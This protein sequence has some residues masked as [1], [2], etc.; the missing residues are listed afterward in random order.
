MK[1][2]KKLIS[3]VLICSW[4]LFLFAYYEFWMRILLKESSISQWTFTT[5][6]IAFVLIVFWILG[7]L[8]RIINFPIKKILKI[9]TIPVNAITLWLFSLV[10][11]VI[12][13]YLFQYVAN[14]YIGG[15]TVELWTILQTFVLSLLMAIGITV[16][17]KIF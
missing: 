14:N 6:N 5:E 9:L 15:V 8:F 11:N 16:L 7:L 13:F 3:N 17:N 4:L 12:V 2:I 1:V 10:L